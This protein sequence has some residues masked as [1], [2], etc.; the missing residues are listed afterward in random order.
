MAGRPTAVTAAS[1]VGWRGA[2]AAVAAGLALGV[3]LLASGALLLY[4]GEGVLGSAGFL[5]ALTLGSLAAGIWV[6]APQPGAARPGRIMGRWMLAVGALV[7]ASFTAMAW[8]RF[9]ALQLSAVG[10]PLALVLLLAEPA[11]AIGA[12]VT[13]LGAR[14]GQ[15]PG[16]WGVGASGRHGI[17]GGVATFALL[18]AAAGVLAAGFWLIPMLPPGP[19]FIGTA[20]LLAAAG[21]LEMSGST[22]E[23]DMTDRVV[24]VTGVGGR[25]QMGYALAEALVG[26]GARVAMVGRSGDLEGLA[27]EL[28]D[29]A[30]AVRADLATEEGATTAVNA[31]V[32]RWG[33]LDAVINAVGG[34]R[35]V[36]PLAETSA[37]EWD[38]EVARNA[39]TAF[40]VSRAA[41]PA[42]RASRGAIVN[43]ASPAVPTGA[44]NLGAYLAGK[45]A[46]VALTRTL[47]LEE[48]A[49][50]VRVNAIAPG[51]IDTE[52]NREAV[53][54][55]ERVRWVTRDEV[56]ETALF[57]AGESG[58]GVTGQVVA[59]EGQGG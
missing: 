12:L 24:L 23:E 29:A 36:R 44:K 58:A 40:L 2:V 43:F 55:P 14:Y 39:R 35:V 57:L 11:Y 15:I 52:S 30:A 56:A 33:R 10:P 37:E 45:A 18:G 53:D 42:L 20:L 19:L 27:R 48:Q 49:N 34:L 5:M 7:V 46:V 22:T 41:L 26:R 59:V 17:P 28:G 31:A 54:D 6:A 32:E 9:P 4:T 50:G 8:L 38:D 21:T 1:L 3:T 13:A 51:M 25:G 47:A 16:R